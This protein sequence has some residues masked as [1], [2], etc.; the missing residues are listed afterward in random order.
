VTH[1]KVDLSYSFMADE[2]GLHCSLIYSTDLFRAE[3]AEAMLT[4]LRCLA[5]A[6]I[7]AP[8]ERIDRL[9]M[10]VE[11]ERHTV[12]YAFNDTEVLRSQATIVSL[13]EICAA[14]HAE[15]PAVIEGGRTVSYRELNAQANRLAHSFAQDGLDL[16][17]PV[18][19]FLERSIDWVTV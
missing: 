17:S 19:V 3:R 18:A 6:A 9:D 1:A 11:Q 4:Q 12:L 14:S 10:L 15:A 2:T 13:F 16:E 7:R 5:E 8:G